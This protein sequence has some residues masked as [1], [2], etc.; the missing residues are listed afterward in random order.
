MRI[1]LFRDNLDGWGWIDDRMVLGRKYVVL[2]V[3][4]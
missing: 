1:V 3:R 2:R 4:C